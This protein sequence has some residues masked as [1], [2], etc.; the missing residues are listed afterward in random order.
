M[1]FFGWSCVRA[2]HFD[3]HVILQ[4]IVWFKPKMN[5]TML[6]TPRIACSLGPRTKFSADFAHKASCNLSNPVHPPAWC[7]SRNAPCAHALEGDKSSK[8]FRLGPARARCNRTW[9]VHCLMQA[10]NEHHNATNKIRQQPM[11]VSP[12]PACSPAPQ[13]QSTVDLHTWQAA[14]SP[15]LCTRL[16]GVPY[17]APHAHRHS[18]AAKAAKIPIGIDKTS[19]QP[20]LDSA[21]P[22]AGLKRTPQ[23]DERKQAATFVGVAAPSQQPCPTNLVQRRFRAQIHA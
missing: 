20:D 10:R 4:C 12:R 9:T 15:T 16:H 23:C 13:T 7:S 3:A 18:K 19:L 14:S 21:L 1:F 11:L 2:K 6:L 17:A 8:K 22:D 5:T